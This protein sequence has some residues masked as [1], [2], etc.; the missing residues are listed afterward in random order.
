VADVFL[1]YSRRD[2]AFVQRL[3]SALRER[4]KEVWVDVEGIRDAEV[5]RE[6]L[7]RAVESSDGFVFVISPDSV[8]SSFCVEEVEHAASLNKRIVPI[9]LRPVSDGQV[10]EG[11][12]ERN[13]IPAGEDWDF[14]TTINRVLKALDTD[15]EWERE[16]SRLTVKAIEW[17]QSGRNR[18]FLLRGAD[19]KSA[20]R[21]LSAGAEKDPG[22][23]A[24]EREYLAASRSRVR[25]GRGFTT[26][27]IAVSLATIAVL[28]ALLVAPGAGVHVGPNSLA[29]IDP[30]TNTVVGSVPVG[31]RPGPVTF[32]SGSLWVANQDDQT[33]SRINPSTMQAEG[34]ISLQ[35]PPTG[36]AAGG[37]AV[38]VAQANPGEGSVSLSAIDP[39]FNNVGPARRFATVVPGDGALVATQG[40]TVWLAP[41]SGDL[42]QLDATIQKILRR[43]DPN[44]GPNAIAVGN[45]AVWLTDPEAN[46]VTRVAP[47]GSLKTIPVGNGPAA[48]AVGPGGV[49][50]TDSLD[51][52]VK[53]IDPSTQSVKATIPVGRSPAGVATGAGSV[54][55]ADSGDGTI[56]R[57]DPRTDKVQAM[58]AV[59][60]SPQAVTIAD[61]RVWVTVDAQTI[62]PTDLASGGGTLRIESPGGLSAMDPAFAQPPVAWQVQYAVCAKLFNYP[63]E[64]GLAGTRLT[65]EVATGLPT[66]SA[67]GKTYTFTIRN[68]FR[69]SPPSN[70]PVTA[71]TFKYTIERSL[72]PKIIPAPWAAFEDVVG[73]TAYMTGKA[74]DI[75]GIVARG[76]ELAIHLLSPAPDLAA[77]LTQPQFC[78]VPTDTPISPTPVRLVPSAGPY[79]ATS[80][81]PGQGVVLVRNPNYRGSRP[82][83]FARIEL[84]GG[85]SSQRAASD[86][87]AGTA[88]YAPLF[89]PGPPN[90]RALTSELAARYGRGSLAARHGTQQYYVNPLPAVDYYYLNTHRPLFADVRIRR[91][92]NYAVDRRALARLGTFA[93]VSDRPTDHY[94]P[95]GIP[96]YI[97]THVYPLTPNLPKARALAQGRGRGRTAVLYTC[98]VYPCA[99]E[100]QILKDALEAIGVQLQFK[101]FSGAAMYTH[102]QRPGS[103]FDIGF[104]GWVAGFP[105]PAD[106][107]PH[108]L[109]ESSQYPPFNDPTYQREL[110]D[111]G[112]L[113]GPARYLA[114]RKL[115]LDLARNAAPLLAYGTEVTPDFFSARIGCQTYGFYG[116]DLD[117]LCIRPGA[118]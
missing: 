109:E 14:D 92:F 49:W 62:K 90:L 114:Y 66:R 56:A 61:G 115:D 118:R 68:G 89:A 75:S 108:M 116:M 113:T 29:A 100:A 7:R 59:G 18:S 57:I 101:A 19:L 103:P 80:Y 106:M 23:T 24:L 88:D 39:H 105:D 22:P 50:V 25:R 12:R 20:E 15:L 37:D 16:H 111:A 67:H 31:T 104:F 30:R 84:Q 70:Q 93:P 74:S 42:T 98:D 97:D 13:W 34:A 43:I 38:W 85:M 28:A 35:N 8:G 44:S 73:A 36:L 33:I 48:V 1:S 65:A 27:A 11:V 10:P 58:I 87:E 3:G 71:E 26:A 46:T 6:A 9:A 17:E 53:Q 2:G 32:G 82:R 79:Y 81:V 45:G 64:P 95:P 55:V 96:G 99:Q 63:D 86:V 83:H 78:A 21:W 94:L 72:S 40:A 41:G 60:G 52:N 117:A 112:R 47:A 5:F 77:R 102:E 76:N 54:W 51:D 107:L 69:F 91:A 4:G 110:N